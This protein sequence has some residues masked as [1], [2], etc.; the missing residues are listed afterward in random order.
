MTIA[1]LT[2][3]LKAI[4]DWVLGSEL[5]GGLEEYAL[6]AAEHQAVTCIERTRASGDR[7][8]E[9][10]TTAAA[11][12][13]TFISVAEHTEF[14]L[15]DETEEVIRQAKAIGISLQ[16]SRARKASRPLSAA[17]KGPAAV[18]VFVDE[19][20][21][22]KFDED[23]QPVLSLVGVLFKDE[24]IPL[25]ES[26]AAA[27]L[28]RHGLPKDLEFHAKEF[29]TA[30]SE[31]PLAHLT[32][33]ERYG[34]LREFLVLGMDRVC[35]IHHLGM[36]KSMVT[37]DYRQKMLAQGLNPYSH[38]VVWFLVTLDRACLVAAP[39]GYRYFYD[40]TD[41]YRKDIGRIFRAL[42][43]TPHPWL[44]LFGFKGPA[45]MLE[46]HESRL[47]QLA[48]VAGYFL[49]RHRQFEIRTFKHRAE[50]DKHADK[51]HEMYALIQPKLLDYIGKDLY[52]TVDWRALRQFSL[53]PSSQPRPPAGR[54]RR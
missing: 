15:S 41:A 23:A 49:P 10:L 53:K 31:G 35:G 13:Q 30:T 38:T 37:H 47:I 8:E 45:V 51:I 25:F 52:R 48:D 12:L 44:R 39:G 20:G 16:E 46:S 17:P 22:A 11:I 27:L 5:A 36:L 33:D 21:T 29:L 54:R 3:D 32:A 26:A 34:L 2:G 42:E 19:S 7:E 1:D 28:E 24:A 18:S 4:Q 43:S 6:A 14:P 9:I 50:L 40:R